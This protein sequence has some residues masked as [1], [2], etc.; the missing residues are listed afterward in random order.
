MAGSKYMRKLRGL[1]GPVLKLLNRNEMRRPT[2]SQFCAMCDSIFSTRTDVDTPREVDEPQ[3]AAAVEVESPAA[4]SAGRDRL[5]HSSR[6]GNRAGSAALSSDMHSGDIKPSR[7]QS[8]VE[9]LYG[10]DPSSMSN[11][12]DPDSAA[13]VDTGATLR[14]GS[15]RRPVSSNKKSRVSMPLRQVQ[16]KHGRHRSGRSS[17]P[18]PLPETPQHQA[19][20]S[21]TLDP[22]TAYDYDGDVELSE[23]H[24][25]HLLSKHSAQQPSRRTP[26]KPT[27]LQHHHRGKQTTPRRSSMHS[28][29]AELSPGI[30]HPSGN[31]PT[32]LNRICSPSIDI[33]EDIPGLQ[34]LPSEQSSTAFRSAQSQSLRLLRD[35]VP[36]NQQVQLNDLEGSCAHIRGTPSAADEVNAYTGERVSP[37]CSVCIMFLRH[38]VQC[39]CWIVL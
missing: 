19:D 7:R 29:H 16:Q 24:S 32:S 33:L 39:R 21:N 12:A 14:H 2:M 8:R 20:S 5:G 31:S 17:T 13:V 30:V 23:M 25:R 6:R 28:Q 34:N 1:R 26:K 15:S 38:Q 10:G 37:L 36:L 35:A 18:K 4:H 9:A 27:S 3:Q 11:D 22:L